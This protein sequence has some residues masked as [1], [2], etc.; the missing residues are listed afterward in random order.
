MSASEQILFGSG[1]ERETGLAKIYKKRRKN[2]R[3]L[4]V[5]GYSS[6]RS[7]SSTEDW[8]TMKYLSPR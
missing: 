2:T 1:H 8:G 3:L 7:R 5:L 6:S 4:S